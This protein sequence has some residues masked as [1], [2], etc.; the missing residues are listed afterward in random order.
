MMLLFISRQEDLHTDLVQTACGRR[1]VACL[2]LCTRDF[3]GAIGLS[4]DL[5]G[6][7]LDG[8]LRTPEQ[9]VALAAIQGI[10]YRRPEPPQPHPDLDQA[11]AQFVRRE[12]RDAL[13]GLYR[14]LWDRRWV[15]PPHHDGAAGYKIYQ[16]RLAQQVGF[17]TPKTIVTNN[18][19]EVLDFFR[20]CHDRVV[21]KLLYPL[22][23]EESDDMAAGIYTTPIARSDLDA[24]LDSVRV[25]PCLFQE[26]IPKRYELRINVI[27]AYVWATAIYS[28]E[29]EDTQIDYRWDIE[30]C[31]HAPVVLPRALE[32]KCLEITRRLGLRMCNIDMILT[33]DGE[34]IFLEINPNGQWGWIEEYVGFPLTT[35]LIDELLGVDTLA[36]HPYLKQRSLAF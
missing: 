11:Y 2:R 34:Y 18:P 13:H 33:P 7:R 1:G 35:A 8:W 16:L 4:L 32:A 28:Q 23:V 20:A 30:H 10:W 22:V 36:D 19:T 12:A 6:G 14:A 5:D 15:N 29:R 17:R 26:L 9:E 31:R 24:H 27:G 21:Y 3:P 25:A